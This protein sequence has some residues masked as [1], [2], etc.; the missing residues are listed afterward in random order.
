[1]LRRN[2]N[3]RSRTAGRVVVGWVHLLILGCANGWSVDNISG[4]PVSSNSSNSVLPYLPALM[5]KGPLFAFDEMVRHAT[6]DDLR[7][8]LTNNSI[9]YRTMA[10]DVIKTRADKAFI[11]DLSRALEDERAQVRVEAALTL[12]AFGEPKGRIAL[13]N[14]VTKAKEARARLNQGTVRR[15]YWDVEDTD[16]WSKGAGVLADLGDSTGYEV[17]KTTLLQDDLYGC[18]MLAVLEIPKFMRFKDKQA[19]AESVL[20]LTADDA[21]GRIDK[22]LAENPDKRP[23]AQLGY[24]DVVSRMLAQVG[25][26]QE[27][28]KLKLYAQ[29]KNPDVR[30]CA[31][32]YLHAIERKKQQQT[33]TAPQN[34]ITP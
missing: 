31:T 16:A 5:A 9:A 18:R 30:F 20:L 10:I 26:E 22:K 3:D 12:D 24:L 19:D 25:G 29:H 7:F 34:S 23:S 11:A 27:V 8:E 32:A 13:V 15:T 28:A 33:G 2:P 6:P 21:I 4:Q 14:E 1:M 17:V